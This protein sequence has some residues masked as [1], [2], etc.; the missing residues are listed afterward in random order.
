MVATLS[1]IFLSKTKYHFNFK[2]IINS[3]DFPLPPHAHHS[4]DA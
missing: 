4:C 3:R 1:K 2:Q